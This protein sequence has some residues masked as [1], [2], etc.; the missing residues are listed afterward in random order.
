MPIRIGGRSLEVI[1]LPAGKVRAADVPFFA[2]AVGRQNECA[3]ARAYQNP[4][5]AH[6]FS[7]LDFAFNFFYSPLLTLML[8]DSPTRFLSLERFPEIHQLFF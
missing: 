5:S 7:F 3:F 2:L 4:Y 8:W 1:H 6:A